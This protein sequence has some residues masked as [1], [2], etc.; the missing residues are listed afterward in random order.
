MN[1]A[2]SLTIIRTDSSNPT[3]MELVRVL[4][5]VLAELDGPEHEFY[6]Q[7]HMTHSLRH[8]VLAMHQD[9]AIGCGAIK[10]LESG[11]VE[12]KRMFV[13]PEYRDQAVGSFI[14]SSL[15]AWALEMG[16]RKCVLETGRRQPD[17][18]RLY[19]KNGYREIPNYGQYEGMPNSICFEKLIP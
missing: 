17:A 3:F 2:L 15:E 12:V 19:T 16:M 10:P 5:A 6:A 18:I 13:Q 7:F 11:V 8:V 14:L 1:T 4:D 9:K